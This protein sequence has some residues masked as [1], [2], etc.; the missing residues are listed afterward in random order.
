M[1]PINTLVWACSRRIK[2][3]MRAAQSGAGEKALCS[4]RRYCGAFISLKGSAV[5]HGVKIHAQPL[6]H[7][8]LWVRADPEQAE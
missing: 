1:S 8:A 7:S 4:C 3:L 6:S 2:V 5:L